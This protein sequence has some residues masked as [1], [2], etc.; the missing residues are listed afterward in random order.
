MHFFIEKLR[1]K[2]LA[3]ISEMTIN[4]TKKWRNEYSV[5]IHQ[6]CPTKYI[7]PYTYNLQK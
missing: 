5:H 1:C 6:I 2:L 4:K 3:Y 7:I